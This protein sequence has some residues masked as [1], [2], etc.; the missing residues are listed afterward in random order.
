MD[1]EKKDIYFKIF[2]YNPEVDQESYFDEFKISVEKGITILRAM[3]YIKDHVD[4]KLSYRFFCQAGI[5]GSCAMKVNG[6]AKLACTTQVWDELKKCKT[7][8]VITIEPLG[9]LGVVRDM[10]IN[11]NPVVDKLEKFMSWVEPAKKDSAFGE[12]EFI[13]AEKDFKII[14]AATDCILCASCYS[15]CSILDAHKDFVSPLVMLKAF[16]MNADTRDTASQKRLN[17]LTKDHGI[18]DC[19]HCYKCVEACVKNIP[20]MDGIHGLRNSAMNRGMKGEGYRHADAFRKD[21][22]NV[23]RL[24]EPLL[25]LRTKGIFK[26]IGMTSFTIKMALKGRLPSLFVKKIPGL[27]KVRELMRSTSKR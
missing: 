9:N 23:G 3:N 12:K 21:I 10:V 14:D 25:L 18:W 6:V 20:I 22:Y 26:V 16:R 24:N 15:E 19:T 5:C 2:R 8:D 13:V 17:L 11:Y 27:K 4:P 1:A 7:P